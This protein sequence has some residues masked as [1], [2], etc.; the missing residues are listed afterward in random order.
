MSNLIAK[1]ISSGWFNLDIWS[2]PYV[3]AHW[4]ITNEL[5]QIQYEC[6]VHHGP[7]SLMEL[8]TSHHLNEV[9]FFKCVKEIIS[10]NPSKHSTIW[11]VL[12]VKLQVFERY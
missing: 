11:K 3:G 2:E 4:I 5:P 1:T 6:S 8:L 10:N 7:L 9:M 12:F